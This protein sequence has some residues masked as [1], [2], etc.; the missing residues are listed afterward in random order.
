M[1]PS[2]EEAVQLDIEL[3]QLVSYHYLS[4]D[5]ASCASQRPVMLTYS[6][7]ENHLKLWNLLSGRVE[8]SAHFDER[9]THACLH[10]SGLYL[11]VSFFEKVNLYAVCS[12]QLRF[13]YTFDAFIGRIS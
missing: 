11:A 2:R 7:F 3:K 12:S 13:L 4:I 10:S 8:L 6:S 1:S 5:V 9:S